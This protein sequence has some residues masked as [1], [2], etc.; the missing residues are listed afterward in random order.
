MS[1]TTIRNEAAIAGTRSILTNLKS[2]APSGLRSV[3][4]DL[5]LAYDDPLNFWG[6][7]CDVAFLK[8]NMMSM[9]GE[10]LRAVYKQ[11]GREIETIKDQCLSSPHG[12][13]AYDTDFLARF[14]IENTAFHLRHHLDV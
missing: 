3:V 4:I 8:T 10:D 13:V 2:E 5:A 7:Y 11:Y 12:T 14:A 6:E 1:T 9:T